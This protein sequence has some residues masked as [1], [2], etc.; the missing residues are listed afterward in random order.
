VHNHVITHGHGPIKVLALHGWFGSA[1]GWG[2]MVEALDPERFTFAFID[3]RGYGGSKALAGDY[4]LA[5]IAADTL[6]AA[7]RLGWQRFALMGHSMGGSAIQ[8]VLA[9]APERVTA[10]VAVTPVPATGVPFDDATWALFSSAAH[11]AEA[12]RQIVDGSTGGRL[13]R[14]WV[15]SVVAHS[16]EHSTTEAFGA[17]LH[18]WARTDFSARIAGLSLPV[19][20]LV[21]EHDPGLTE[22]A[23]RATWLRFYPNA[24]LQVIG[25]AGHYPMHET[26]VALATAVQDFLTQHH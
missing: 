18:A 7:D 21:G 8:H 13:S 2:A 19:Q 10:L 16:L 24:Q 23:M 26:P 14:H 5:E 15:H 20:V 3:Y 6:R 11:S 4:T 1:G 12:R 17:Y 22:Q 25:N 9:D